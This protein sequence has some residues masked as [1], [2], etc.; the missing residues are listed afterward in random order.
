MSGKIE[1]R[2]DPADMYCGQCGEWPL[3]DGHTCEPPPRGFIVAYPPL[4]DGITPEQ[5]AAMRAKR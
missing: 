1:Y 5:W 3:Y 4:Q 2:M